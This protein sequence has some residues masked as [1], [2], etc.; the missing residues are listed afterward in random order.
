MQQLLAVETLAER[1]AGYGRARESGAL[2]DRDGLTT[3]AARFRPEAT[4]LLR[5]LVYRGALPRGEVAA[6]TGLEERTA[7][8]LIHSLVTEG[9]LISSSSRAPL[10]FRI[11]AHAA[12]YFFPDLYTPARA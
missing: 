7:R 1:V 5:D 9:F 6:L 11:P 3:R 4:R 12:P 2:P 10:R 8:R